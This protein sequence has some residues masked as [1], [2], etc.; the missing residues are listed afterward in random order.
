[1]PRN[2]RPADNRPVQDQL[3]DLIVLG[4]IAGLYDAVDLVLRTHFDRPSDSLG[5]PASP[6]AATV[7]Q[8]TGGGGGTATVIDGDGQCRA[9]GG[10]KR[11]LRESG[12]RERR[13]RYELTQAERQQAQEEERAAR[14]AHIEHLDQIKVGRWTFR[15]G[16]SVAVDK[17]A[18]PV[19]N[20]YRGWLGVIARIE[21][22]T[23]RGKTSVVV[24]GCKSGR[25]GDPRVSY[26]SPEHLVY[27]R[28][29]TSRAVEAKGR[30]VSD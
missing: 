19:A 29:G 17:A 21:R 26:V 6:V 23:K 3:R 8:G 11:C 5:V 15:P 9:M 28:P 22:D 2:E 24:K 10:G 25:L 18:E 7:R 27:I 30:A 14:T 20:Q 12:H 1:M 13:H 4:N 16:D